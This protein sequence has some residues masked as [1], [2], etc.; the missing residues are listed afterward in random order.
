MQ[1]EDAADAEVG[2]VIGQLIEVELAVVVG[3]VPGGGDL[4]PDA[5]ADARLGHDHVQLGAGSDLRRQAEDR[6][7]GAGH[8]IEPVQRVAGLEA[9]RVVADGQ[10][11]LDLEGAVERDE[12][13]DGRQDRP[14]DLMKAELGVELRHVPDDQI[15]R[16]AEEEVDNPF[17][18]V[19]ERETDAEAVAGVLG[20]VGQ[21][22]EVALGGAV[23]QAADAAG[24][25]RREV[26]V[27]GV[28][29]L[30][31][32]AAG[33]L[34]GVEIERAEIHGQGLSHMDQTQDALDGVVDLEEIVQ[35]VEPGPQCLE[36]VDESHR[37]AAEQLRELRD[38]RNL[39]LKDLPDRLQRLKVLV[40][41]VDDRADDRGDERTQVEGD[42]G[43]LG[44]RK[45]LGHG[46]VAADAPVDDERRGEVGPLIAVEDLGVQP[47]VDVGGDAGV[48][49][50]VGHLGEIGQGE[51]VTA[52]GRVELQAQAPR[53]AGH[54]GE[55]RR[56]GIIG[57]G[58]GQE[59]ERRRQAA[60]EGGLVER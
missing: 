26:A 56:R 28:V 25:G 9:A 16:L 40:H 24:Q 27:V 21:A 22:L 15:D 20:R 10:M 3:V 46:G 43:Q 55:F 2:E 44:V 11:A 29:V 34:A 47:H 19:E 50:E 13:G 38:D 4:A 32:D 14:E 33:Q 53:D 52:A 23:G 36:R 42:V 35:A 54:V 12:E 18:I 17:R 45:A 6:L 1:V 37:P 30:A 57:G 58:N 5:A 60:A 59:G 31:G 8:E 39:R 51:H 48:K 49:G 7:T 41:L